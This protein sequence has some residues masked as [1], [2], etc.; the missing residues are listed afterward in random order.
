M[1]Q[2]FQASHSGRRG[3]PEPFHKNY[4]ATHNR[5]GRQKDCISGRMVA[6][7]GSRLQHFSVHPQTITEAFFRAFS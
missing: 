6:S 2:K 4:S 5:T 7:A 1:R 3:N